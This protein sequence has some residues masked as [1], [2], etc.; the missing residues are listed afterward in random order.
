MRLP[1]VRMRLRICGLMLPLLGTWSVAAPAVGRH[2]AP[3]HVGYAEVPD[4]EFDGA[5]V[6]EAS[7][8]APALLPPL[9]VLAQAVRRAPAAYRAPV[10]VPRPI[11]PIGPIAPVVD[12]APPMAVTVS[13]PKGRVGAQAKADRVAV[14]LRSQGMSVEEV[15][16]DRQAT[17]HARIL[18]AYDED[19]QAAAAVDRTLRAAYGLDS[20]T[21]L[22]PVSMNGRRPGLVE[23]DLPG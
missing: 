7:G 14:L 9:P 11:A 10:P 12:Q 18:F 20:P 6:F 19:R 23:V 17:S 21:T 8:A 22:A 2:D 16:A 4:T 15:Q 1:G 5:I 13:F 3:L